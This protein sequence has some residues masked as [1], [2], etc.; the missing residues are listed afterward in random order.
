[1]TSSQG[2]I[3]VAEYDSLTAQLLKDLLSPQGYT[4]LLA[5]DGVEALSKA[6][7]EHPDLILLDVGL[8][9]LSGI[10]VCQELKS[11]EQTR[12]IP[13]IL[14]TAMSASEA[15]VFSLQIG[16]D[17]FIIKPFR[18]RELMARIEARLRAKR[19]EDELRARVEQIKGTFQRYV[20]PAVVERLL[21]DPEQV[22]LGGQLQEITVL[23]ADLRGFTVLS[24]QRSVEE[25]FNILN[26]RMTLAAQ[27]VIEQEGTLDK[28]LGDGLM[29]LFNAPLPQPDHALRAARAALTMQQRM[30]E[31]T[32]PSSK[33]PM[34]F[35]IGICTGDALVGNIGMP[36][37]MNY[38]A[39]GH[40]VNMA[41]RLQETAQAG[42]ILLCATTHQQIADQA[43]SRPL[44][45]HGRFGGQDYLDAFELLGLAD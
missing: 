12:E 23:F 35:G 45:V 7:F 41:K 5:R 3:L 33:A 25:V 2:R 20:A 42:Q 11:K 13:V 30:A 29:A 10:E 19:R 18:S 24:T 26:Q 27:A 4:V 9:V 40:P 17:D 43:Q 31:L 44:R 38:T 1:M 22:N 39:I 16:V 37:L 15:K 6:R 14:M 32:E 36:Q 21:S 8:P 34:R 28:F